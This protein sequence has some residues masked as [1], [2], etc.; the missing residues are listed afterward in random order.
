[1]IDFT[2]AR[3]KLETFDTADALADFFRHEQ[4]KG[5]RASPY[6]CPIA[7]WL[8][9]VTG[10]ECAASTSQTW[11][12]NEN[13]EFWVTAEPDAVEHSDAMT[14]FIFLFDHGEYPDLEEG[15]MRPELSYF[16]EGEE[17]AEE[18]YLEFMARL[19]D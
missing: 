15:G 8:T 3:D 5:W 6:S 4:V 13:A 7:R 16:L 1:M 10:V 2:V 9:E 14:N 18:G 11:P 12:K 17:E 19:E